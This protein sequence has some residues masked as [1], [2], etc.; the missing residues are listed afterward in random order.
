MFRPSIAFSVCVSVDIPLSARKLKPT[1][2]PACLAPPAVA[3][4]CTVQA[5]VPQFHDPI[6]H[7]KQEPQP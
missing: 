4:D 6:A 5:R 3:L 1:R 7:H 2:L